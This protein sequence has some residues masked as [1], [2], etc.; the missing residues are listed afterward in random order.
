MLKRLLLA[1]GILL[2]FFWLLF[3]LKDIV[4]DPSGLKVSNGTQM[5]KPVQPVN[6]NQMHIG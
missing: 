2:L 4:V 5:K 3:F 1:S 6:T